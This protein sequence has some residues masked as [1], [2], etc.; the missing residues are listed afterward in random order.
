MLK[1]GNMIHSI[2]I[3][4][5][6][7]MAGRGRV[8]E[9]LPVSDP[10]IKVLR[11]GRWQNMFRPVNPDR[12]FSGVC[13][14]ESFAKKYVEEHNVELGIIPCADGGTSLLQWREG[15]LLYDHAVMQARL[16][17]RT[18]TIVAV[19]WHQ[20]EADCA[21]HLAEA[22]YDKASAIFNALRRDLKLGDVPFIV[23]GLGDFLPERESV[24]LYNYTAVN[25]QLQ[26]LAE[27]DALIGF[28]SAEGLTDNGDHLHF[29]ARSLY[30][31]GERYYA[32]FLKLEKRDRVFLEKASPDDA[33]R[34]SMEAL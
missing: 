22:Y 7:N 27:N 34:S 23:G 3:I 18:S 15:G 24:H 25:A 14:A 5:Q 8:S 2:L 6:S 17:E 30:E 32:E 12:A 13:L 4:G 26:K 1:R 11:N 19:L 28:A 16:A 9:A 10:R 33:V 31:F 21:P 29:D 20:G